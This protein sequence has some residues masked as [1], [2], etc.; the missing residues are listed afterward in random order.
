MVTNI[1][2]YELLA[3]ID[4]G[5]VI[6]DVLPRREYESGHIPA[7]ANLPLKSLDEGAVASMSRGKPVV[8][9]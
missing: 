5:A 4:E 2:R 8:V 3:L 9:Y 7:A 1:D 6:L